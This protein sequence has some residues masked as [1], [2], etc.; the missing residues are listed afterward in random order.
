LDRAQ[1]RRSQ[2]GAVFSDPDGEGEPRRAEQER[3]LGVVRALVTTSWYVD[4]DTGAVT[5]GATSEA[6]GPTGEWNGTD[7]N[8]PSSLI[9]GRRSL[10]SP[11]TWTSDRA[12]GAVVQAVLRPHVGVVVRE[13]L[14]G[15][16]CG[17][18]VS[19]DVRPPGNGP[20]HL[21]RATVQ[22]TGTSSSAWSENSSG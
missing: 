21:R 19:G 11:T 18:L 9:G 13:P 14:A 15:V 12:V 4:G 20:V 10:R 2:R 16:P 1:G 3:H 8:P 17:E 22:V 6:S 5:T 7:V